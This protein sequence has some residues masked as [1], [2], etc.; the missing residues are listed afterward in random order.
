MPQMQPGGILDLAQPVPVSRVMLVC[1]HCGE[2]T[3]VAHR[4]LENGRRVRI[5]R[6]CDEQLEAKA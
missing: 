6:H 5:C 3:R 2:P 1:G 4:E